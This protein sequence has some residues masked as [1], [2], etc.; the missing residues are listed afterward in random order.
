M[1]AVTDTPHR[2]P[3]L[4]RI[5]GDEIPPADPVPWRRRR[6]A[7]Q[8]QLASA[9]MARVRP[10]DL[11]GVGAPTLR[12][13]GAD[14]DVDAVFA[15]GVM[16]SM[17]S[18]STLGT[19]AAAV[20][21]A[22]T[23]LY[24]F[25][26]RRDALPSFG[27]RAFLLPFPALALASTLWSAA[28]GETLKYA[29]ELAITVIAA[30]LISSAAN[31]TAMVRAIA[32]AF[33]VYVA[34]AVALGG[35]V[36]V[37]VG[38]GGYAFSGLTESKNLIA[39]IAGTGLVF[40]L[41]A[42]AIGLARR[43][44]LWA[45]LFVMGALVEG[46][47]LVAARSAGAL[48]AVLLACV[49]LGGLLLLTRVGRAARGWIT[50]MMLLVV[51]TAG[52]NFRALAEAL[53]RFGADVFDKDPTLTGRTYLW[54]RAGELMHDTPL[55]GRGYSA[56]WLQGN[57]DAEGLWQFAGIAARGGFNFH[58]TFIELRVV[59]GWVGAAVFFGM[60]ALGLVLLI[61]RYVSRPTLPLVCWMSVA[62]Y[63][64]SRMALES[65]AFQQFYHPT[66]LLFAALGMGVGLQAREAVRKPMRHR[67]LPAL[68]AVDYVRTQDGW[69]ALARR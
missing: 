39:D 58:N 45:G 24:L 63:E 61:R 12:L 9:R 62:L 26:R 22:L 53:I 35:Q 5:R 10:A 8:A 33:L 65:I 7:A 25:V 36:K 32:L 56:F 41:S 47:A 15:F 69:G 29:V 67:T 18:I 3:A 66:L 38:L 13:L 52:L 1:T 42:I 54:Y 34:N 27:R 43:Q 14:V 17:L 50:S 49:A 37:G 19:K 55:L 59:L 11:D 2:P 31:K 21:A 28:P 16:V 46:Y 57:T 48:M 60:V 30:L 68:P 20:I 44:L 40:S 64:V 23:P 51:V 4:R 6:A